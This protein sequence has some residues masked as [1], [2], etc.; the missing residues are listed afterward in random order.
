ME[1]LATGFSLTLLFTVI[2][3]WS[4]MISSAIEDSVDPEPFLT[5]KMYTGVTFL[6]ASLTGLLLKLKMKRNLFVKF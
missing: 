5:Y 1:K 2:A 3:L 6:L 4:P